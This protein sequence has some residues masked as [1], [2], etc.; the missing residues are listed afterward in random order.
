MWCVSVRGLSLARVN[1]WYP[2]A[3]E[4]SIKALLQKLNATCPTQNR[5]GKKAWIKWS[6]SGVVSKARTQGD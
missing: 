5:P 2:A 4:A 1:V 6:N 3:E